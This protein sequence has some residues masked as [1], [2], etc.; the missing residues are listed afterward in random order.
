M[1]QKRGGFHLHDFHLLFC[2][3]SCHK[4]CKKILRVDPEF[5]KVDKFTPT[6]TQTNDNKIF[7]L[8]RKKQKQKQIKNFPNYEDQKLLEN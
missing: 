1:A 7:D 6:D 8:K 5:Y 4:V 3:L 2:A